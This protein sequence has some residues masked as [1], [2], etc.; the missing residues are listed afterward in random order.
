MSAVWAIL[1]LIGG[2]I[3]LGV[4]GELLVRGAARLARGLGISPL[5]VGL[6]VVAY[7]T[8][9]PEAAVCVQAVVQGQ[10]ALAV[11]NVVGSN[12]ANILLILGVAASIRPFKVSLNLLKTDAP[13]MVL[14]AALFVLLS[15]EPWGNGQ[16]VRFEGGLLLIGML[17]YT[18]LTYFMSRREPQ[19]VADEYSAAIG[20]K[21]SRLVNLGMVVVGIAGLV[22]GGRLIVEGASELAFMLGI[23][24]TIVGLTIVAIGTSLP[25]LATSV[26]AIRHNQ[27]DIAI[28]NIVGSNICNILLVVGLSATVSPVTVEAETLYYDCPAMLFASLIFMVIAWTRQ[29][30]SRREGLVLLVFYI[31][32]LAWTAQRALNP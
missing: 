10:D 32:Y 23:S 27:P 15:I 22:L 11:G 13:I 8:S 7:G 4:G 19:V 31:S 16:L 30:I 25:E 28:G 24:P 29:R 2:L 5:V 21:G 20:L 6:T 9:A 18:A 14:V 26:I 1:L 3:T 12:I 17:V